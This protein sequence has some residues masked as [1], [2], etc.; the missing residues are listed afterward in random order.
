MT[1]TDDPRP[2]YRH[3]FIDQK[4]VVRVEHS[5]RNVSVR[6]TMSLVFG[7]WRFIAT[8]IRSSGIFN[9]HFIANFQENLSDAAV[10]KMWRNYFHK[11]GVSLFMGHG[12]RCTNTRTLCPRTHDH[13]FFHSLNGRCTCSVACAWAVY[14]AALKR[15]KQTYSILHCRQRR[16]EP[17]SQ[18]IM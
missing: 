10:V 3:R 11:F 14:S 9:N 5:V 13:V 6:K 8:P 4:L 16:T 15:K 7:H 12:V 1:V 2:L 17:G 18:V